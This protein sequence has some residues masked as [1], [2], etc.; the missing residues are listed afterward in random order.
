MNNNPGLHVKAFNDRVKV[1]NQTGQKDLN[2]SAADAR[3]LHA[4]IFALLSLISE[5]TFQVQAKYEDS[6]I[7]VEMD[8][9]KF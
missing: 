4:D 8:G 7:D 2:L 6:Q 5:L 3:N 1:M 9:G